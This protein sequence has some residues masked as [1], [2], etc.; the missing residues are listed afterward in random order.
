MK[1]ITRDDL[2]KSL[3]KN[4]ELTLVEAMSQTEFDKAHLPGA[5][6]LGHND[7]DAQ[8]PKLLTS[9]TARIVVYG[10]DPSRDAS[11]TVIEKLIA[12]GY[13]NV[14]QYKEGKADWIAAGHPVDR[15]SAQ[16]D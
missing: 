8:A 6:R 5:I 1:T 16:L 11:S 10:A 3:Q 12:L 2:W 13:T 14:S 4:E 9:K 7:V 15:P